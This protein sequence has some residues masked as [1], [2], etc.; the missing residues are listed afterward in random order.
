MTDYLGG[1]SPAEIETLLRRLIQQGAEG[2]KV[3]FKK[4]LNLKEKAAQAE[5]AKDISSIANTDDDAH[6]DDFGYVILGAE[7]GK[8]VGGVAELG[9]DI[10]KLQAQLTDVIKAYVGPV[11][12]FSVSAFHDES[13]GPWGAIVVSP[14]VRQPHLFVRDGAG[15]VVKHEWW[16]R[17]NDTKERAGPHD[18]GRI[19]AKATRRE[20]RPLELEVQ[21]LALKVEQFAV[22]NLDALVQAIQGT[23]GSSAGG[24]SDDASPDLA[25]SVRRLL[26]RGNT[27]VEEALVTEALRVAEVM[28]ETSPRNP[29]VFSGMKGPELQA[30]LSYL[31]EQTFPLAEALATAARY[32]RDGVLIDAVCRSLEVI[33]KEPQPVGTHYTNIA[34]FRL[35]PLVLSLYAV[36]LIAV[37]ERRGELLKRVFNIHLQREERDEAGPIVVSFRRLRAASDV[38]KEALGQN[39]F[40]PIAVRARDV[41]VPRL[42]ALL[43]GTPSKDAFY[44][45]EFVIGLAFL[46][47][48]ASMFHGKVPLPGCYVYESAAQGT[49]KNFL[50][51]RPE[52]LAEALGEP[53]DSLLSAFDQ[54]VAKVVNERGWADGFTSGAAEAYGAADT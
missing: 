52:W 51:Q 9:G 34:Q 25:S 40:E 5:L 12:Q 7:K 14:S 32:D 50:K 29:W 21:R 47:M 17:V 39:F 11:P 6:L 15:D 8:L 48:S 38:F 53:L 36:T 49:L 24:A 45:A 33:A 2:P 3:D 10:D 46:K 43:V 1:R 28:A 19:L 13:V 31:E 23:R 42:S 41:L 4:E 35:Y 27:A 26:V 18:Y 20:V 54:T 37:N 22:P 30:V 44:L 16:V